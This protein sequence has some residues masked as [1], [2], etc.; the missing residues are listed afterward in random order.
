MSGSVAGAGLVHKGSAHVGP[1][2]TRQTVPVWA[3]S[4]G[5]RCVPHSTASSLSSS[6]NSQ[7]KPESGTKA[8]RITS[9]YPE[10]KGPA[11]RAA[12]LF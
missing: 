4:T 12:L 3:L 10:E 2:G 5:Q 8:M 11:L 6:K 9:N 7:E 1:A